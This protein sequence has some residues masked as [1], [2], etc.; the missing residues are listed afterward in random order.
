MASARLKIDP[1]TIQQ[2]DDG[3]EVYE[4]TPLYRRSRLWLDDKRYICRTETF[5]D[6]PVQALNA[7][8]RKVM[9]GKRWTSGS[10]S[11]RGGNMP[12]VRVARIPVNKFLA[13]FSEKL[14]EG[15]EDHAKWLLN[16]E[17]YAP[18]RT[19]SGRL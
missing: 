7:E 18:F 2:R 12:M 5:I 14:K 6:E 16:S 3:W 13:D 9:D 17:S 11:D 4:V 1:S 15:D 19:R 8:E 10:G